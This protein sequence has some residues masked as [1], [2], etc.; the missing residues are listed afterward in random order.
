MSRARKLIVAS[1]CAG[2]LWCIAVGLL[3]WFL[4]LGSSE[5]QSASSMVVGGQTFASSGPVVVGDGQSFASISALGPV[6]L[7]IPVVLAGIGTW[8]ALR[9]RKLVLIGA[10]ILIALFAFLTGFS[11]GLFYVPAVALLVVACITA[12]SSSVSPPS[13]AGR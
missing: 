7:I 10:T 3:L 11:I 13:E 9:R 1:S 8:S 12:L 4:P 5:S 2:L 6:P